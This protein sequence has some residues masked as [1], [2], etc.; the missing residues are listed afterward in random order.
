M[1]PLASCTTTCT[2]GMTVRTQLT[3]A[4]AD[5]AQRGVMELLLARRRL[6]R[7]LSMSRAERRRERRDDGG[8]PRL[9]REVRARAREGGSVEKQGPMR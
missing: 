5:K 2:E 8:D 7:A 3:S 1:K 9:R 6:D 4:V